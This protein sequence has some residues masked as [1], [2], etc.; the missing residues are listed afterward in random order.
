MANRIWAWLFGSGIVR[1][2]DNFGTT[3]EMPSHSELLDYLAL[4]FQEHNWSIKSLVKDILLSRTWQLSTEPNELAKKQDPDN[5]LLTAYPLR[6]LDAEQ[7]RDAM[8]A[9]NGKLDLRMFGPNIAGAGEINANSTAAQTVEYNYVF[10]DTRRSV[11]TPAFRVKRHE[12]FELFDFGNVNF[13]IGQRNV[14]TVALQALY[15][16]NNPFV[17]EQSKYA[18]ELLLK[19]VKTPKARMDIAFIKT[20]GRMPTDRERALVTT[21]LQDGLSGDSVDDWA[22][23]FQTLF[24]SIDFRYLN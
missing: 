15:M 6:R 1:S 17:I 10:K 11:Y 23:V 3:G 22:S 8:L 24:G 16:L 18:A 21:Y 20:L 7:L 12:L 5:R 14:S 9:V 19:E 13:T 4:Q 2:V